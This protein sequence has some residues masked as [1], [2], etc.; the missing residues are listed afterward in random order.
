MARYALIYGLASG[1][2]IVLVIIAGMTFGGF[3]HSLW[4]GYLAM[5]VA[6][7][8]IFVGVKRYRDVEGGGVVRFWRALALALSIAGVATLAYVAV[9][10]LYLAL[11][12]YTFMDDYTA[13]IIRNAQAHGKTG[14]AL[15]RVR[16]EAANMRAIYANP[17]LRM[18]MTAIEIA[19][20]GVVVALFSAG[21]LCFSKVLPARR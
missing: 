18:G 12:H 11:T 9:W 4:F 1:T 20:V 6:L 15:A 19:P 17:L 14:A 21:L 8:F 7:T 10:E 3:G 5:L 2:I 16:A 13:G